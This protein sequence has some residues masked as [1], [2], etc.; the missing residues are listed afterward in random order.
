ML[1]GWGWRS[2]RPCKKPEKQPIAPEPSQWA[3]RC[4]AKGRECVSQRKRISLGAPYCPISSLDNSGWAKAG[5]VGCN[6]K[7][8]WIEKNRYL[9]VP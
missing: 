7:E 2:G 4:K 9:R 6:K 1:S 8:E 5:V 3:E